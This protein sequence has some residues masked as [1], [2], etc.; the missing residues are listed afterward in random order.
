MKLQI[1]S[2]LKQGPLNGEINFS[3]KSTLYIHL[4][5]VT[6]TMYNQ[7]KRESWQVHLTTQ[8]L[9]GIWELSWGGGQYY[10]EYED[11]SSHLMIDMF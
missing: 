1:Q 9:E 6:N 2:G 5:S 4:K 8:H 10:K 11:F 7:T 3:V